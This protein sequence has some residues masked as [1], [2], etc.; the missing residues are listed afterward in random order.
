MIFATT[1]KNQHI[2]SKIKTHIHALAENDYILK[3][4]NNNAN[5]NSVL[6]KNL[7]CHKNITQTIQQR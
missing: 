1:T 4:R 5:H 7:D 3:S 2:R 6:E